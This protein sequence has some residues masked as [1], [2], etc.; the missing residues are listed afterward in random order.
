MAIFGTVAAEIMRR[1]R[2]KQLA[3]CIA[4]RVAQGMSGS[5]ARAACEREWGAEQ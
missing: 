1:E 4:R 3:E 2:E 5:D